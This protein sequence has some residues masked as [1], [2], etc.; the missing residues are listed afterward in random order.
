[1]GIK[2]PTF[3]WG[4]KMKG[5]KYSV[6]SKRFEPLVH[7]YKLANL[8]TI[9][10]NHDKG[11]FLVIRFLLQFQDPGHDKG[12]VYPGKPVFKFHIIMNGGNHFTRF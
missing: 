12:S 10:V 5:E 1:M 4:N 11:P 3:P 7:V 2:K 9:F 6:K 8:V